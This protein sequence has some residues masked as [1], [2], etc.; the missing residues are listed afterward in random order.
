MLYKHT[1]LFCKGTTPESAAMF[2]KTMWH[3]RPKEMKHGI[4]LSF[5]FIRS[6]F[7]YHPIKVQLYPR[8]SILKHGVPL[9]SQH[10]SA[11]RLP[12]GGFIA[13]LHEPNCDAD[14]PPVGYTHNRSTKWRKVP[15]DASSTR[16][17]PLV[18]YD[19]ITTSPI[20]SLAALKVDSII[21]LSGLVLLCVRGCKP[22]W[23]LRR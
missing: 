7:S 6:I 8:I 19:Q 3:H 20:L 14:A 23:K 5:I 11:P 21:A 22:R 12:P 18:E 13:Q 10:I 1:R 2:P 9:S 16:F 15:A 17:C 4:V